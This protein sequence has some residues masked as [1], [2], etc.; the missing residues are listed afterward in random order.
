M[1]K[2]LGGEWKDSSSGAIFLGNDLNVRPLPPK[3]K[4]AHPFGCAHAFLDVCAPRHFVFGTFVPTIPTCSAF[5][6]GKTCGQTRFSGTFGVLSERLTK[7]PI[8]H[9]LSAIRKWYDLWSTAFHYICPSA[10]FK[11][12]YDTNCGQKSPEQRTI[13][14]TQ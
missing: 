8:F 14:A 9:L 4:W 12:V 3:L 2:A 11:P 10:A 6:Y 13:F 5:V 1:K 7:L